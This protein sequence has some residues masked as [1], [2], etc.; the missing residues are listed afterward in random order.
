MT[1]PVARALLGITLVGLSACYSPPQPKAEPEPADAAANSPGA[2]ARES[3][4]Q[5]P[6]LGIAFALPADRTVGGCTGDWQSE[7]P[8]VTVQ[9]QQGGQAITYVG[10]QAFDGPLEQIAREQAGFEPNAQGQWMTTYGRFEP[11]EVERITGSGWTGMRATITCGIS[12]A[13][14]GFHAAG[15]ECLYQVISN[16]QRSILITTDGIHGLDDATAATLSSIAFTETP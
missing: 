3:L 7:H 16:G 1:T 14:T 2:P 12:D 10:L 9:G 5:A 4:Y 8:C 6:A 11:V 13:E 15:G